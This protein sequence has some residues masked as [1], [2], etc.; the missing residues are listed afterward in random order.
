MDAKDTEHI[1]LRQTV[2]FTVDGQTRTLEIGVP[3]PRDAT[4]QDVETLLDVA[5]AGMRASRAV[6]VC[7]SLRNWTGPTLKCHH[8]QRPLRHLCLRMGTRLRSR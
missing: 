2:T 5:D 3:V 7:A 1:W 8:C 4:A 6:S